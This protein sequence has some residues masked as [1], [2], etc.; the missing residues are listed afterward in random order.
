MIEDTAERDGED[1]V[2]DVIA[3]IFDVAD[4]TVPIEN[5]SAYVYRSLRNRVVDYLRKRKRVMI[6]LD[7]Q[8][9]DDSDLSLS[10]LLHD[11]H[12][13]VSDEMVMRERLER[14]FEIIETLNEDQ[15]AVLIQTEFEGRSFA[16]LS[17]E[18]EIPLGTLLARKSRAMKRIR[19]A[20]SDLDE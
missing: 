17:E 7:E 14:V 12:Y 19:E 2:Q 16:E 13:D 6:S 10:D 15:K 9:F 11:S 5:L 18:W 8:L 20:L 1:I 4:V 3:N